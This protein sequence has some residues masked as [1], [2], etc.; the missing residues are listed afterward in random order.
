MGDGP[1][2][3]QGQGHTIFD[4]EFFKQM[5]AMRFDGLLAD[6]QNQGNFFVRITGTDILENF[7]LFFG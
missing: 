4:P 6:V 2:R 1:G 7:D 3:L 5:I